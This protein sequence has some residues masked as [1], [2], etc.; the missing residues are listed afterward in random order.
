MITEK[1]GVNLINVLFNVFY[2]SN[3]D[4]I[5][6]NLYITA[7]ENDS[8]YSW[9]KLIELRDQF[10]TLGEWSSEYNI[11]EGYRRFLGTQEKQRWNE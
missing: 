7:G 10:R 2:R 3:A 5:M 6:Q 8:S 4:V 11:A 9:R 1:Y